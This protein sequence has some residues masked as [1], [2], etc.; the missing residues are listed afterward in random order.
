MEAP[1]IT[2]F[3]READ[4][5]DAWFDSQPG[6]ALFASEMGCLRALSDGLPRPWLSVGVGTGRFARALEID[7]GVDPAWGTLRYTATRGVRAVAASGQALP[8][9]DDRFGG[10]FVIATLCF[11]DEPIKLL[12]EARRVIRGDGGV[13]LGIVPA[14]SAWGQFYV[15]QRRAGHTFYSVARFFTLAELTRL[16]EAAGLRVERSL[17]TLFQ[18][19]GDSR[20]AVEAPREGRDVAGGFVAVL[21]RRAPAKEQD[22]FG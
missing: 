8:F 1:G 15:A 14:E 9:G 22:R 11:A 6:K 18:R 2:V 16:A 21:C 17:S 4:R 12:R 7:V 10:V 19:P 3:D 20:Y 13:V 5:Y